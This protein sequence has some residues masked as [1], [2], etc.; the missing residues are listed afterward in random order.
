[1]ATSAA[2]IAASQ[3]RDL[4]DRFVALA[5]E[6][7]IQNPQSWVES[8]LSALACAKVADGEDTVASVYE[9]ADAAYQEKLNGIVAPGK[10]PAA[11][12]DDHLRHA[13]N[14]LKG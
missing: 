1:M 9:Y 3:D 11:V 6:S 2:I 7:G 14:T 4:R 5:A 12:T 8:Q 13:I 10:N